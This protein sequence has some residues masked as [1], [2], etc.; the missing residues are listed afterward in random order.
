VITIQAA[1]VAP[2]PQPVIVHQAQPQ[3]QG[4]VALHAHAGAIVSG[5]IEMGGV[6][7]ALRLRPNPRY[8]VELGAGAYAGRDANGQD[9]FEI[10]ITVDG[11]VFLNPENA[12]QAYLMAGVGVST[13]RT[14]GLNENTGSAAPR[15]MLHLGG[16]VGAGLEWRLSDNLAINADVRGFL[17]QRIDQEE[18]P[19]FVNAETGEE[20]D[21]S[22]GALATIGATFYLN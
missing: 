13:A 17:R 22:A 4:R 15:R 18:E 9:R 19:E 8:A 7:G 1:P 2:A 14:E 20:T 16:Q 6:S 11:M 3:T 21:T 12:L 10:P 5:D